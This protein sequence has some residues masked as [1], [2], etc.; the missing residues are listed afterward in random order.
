MPGK[1]RRVGVMFS[2]KCAQVHNMLYTVS[3]GR[4]DQCFAL[5]EHVTCIS[6]YEKDS[7]DVSQCLI[8]RSWII[9]IDKA[10]CPVLLCELF[11]LRFPSP[12]YRTAYFTPL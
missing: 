8:D 7:R 1:N 6:S 5:H 3:L 9:E 4:I 11:Q 12:A 10:R 2:G